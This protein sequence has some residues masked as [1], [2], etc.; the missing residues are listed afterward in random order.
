M[1]Y[2]KLFSE[3]VDSSIWSEDDKTRL[4]WVTMLAKVDKYGMVSASVDGLAHA[5]R[6]S[7]EECQR[8]LDKFMAPDPKSRSQ[9]HE[10]R[11]IKKVDGGFFLLNHARYRNRL[12]EDERRQKKAEWARQNRAAKKAAMVSEIKMPPITMPVIPAPTSA[13]IESQLA[14]ARAEAGL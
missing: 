9:E 1:G 13:D 11:R 7:E 5:A 6:V 3:I 2:T 14:R 8:A 10:G 4:V 12:N